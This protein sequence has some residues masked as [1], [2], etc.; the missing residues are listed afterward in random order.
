MSEWHI[1]RFSNGY[2]MTRIDYVDN[3]IEVRELTWL[4]KI[5][6]WLWGYRGLWK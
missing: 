5:Y 2:R 3:S 1:S 6:Y 4:E